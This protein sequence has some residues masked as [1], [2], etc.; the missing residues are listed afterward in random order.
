MI[1]SND[2][3]KYYKD[4][5]QFKVMLLGE[6]SSNTTKNASFIINGRTYNRSIDE[7]RISKIGINLG[8]GDRKSV[9]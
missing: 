2:L 8:P 1:T 4:E 6:D 9:V 3:V 7:N 5:T